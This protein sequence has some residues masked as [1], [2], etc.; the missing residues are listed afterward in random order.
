MSVI[1][2]VFNNA[3]NGFLASCLESLLSQT[4][5]DIEIIAIDDCSTDAS[6]ELLLEYATATPRITVVHMNE[7]KRQG[8]A[9]NRGI[10][11]AKGRYI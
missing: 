9:R 11:V 1:V 6:L 3:E 2:P 10:E 4:L 8:A 7:N 5:K